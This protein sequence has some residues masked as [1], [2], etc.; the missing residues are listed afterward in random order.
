MTHLRDARQVDGEGSGNL[1]ARL[2]VQHGEVK[3]QQEA[4]ER[5][6]VVQHDRELAALHRHRQQQLVL[7][8]EVHRR[9]RIDVAPNLL[10]L[11]V[12][13]H[14]DVDVR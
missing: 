12:F 6:H 2:R 9:A 13:T 7:D 14:D 4:S 3:A 5:E 11:V 10:P 1:E 8:A